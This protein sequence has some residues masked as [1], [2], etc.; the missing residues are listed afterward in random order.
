MK[1]GLKFKG[2][3]ITLC[4]YLILSEC[5]EQGTKVFFK[6]TFQ[7]YLQQ[8]NGRKVIILPKCHIFPTILAF[9]SLTEIDSMR[10]KF[11][12]ANSIV[13]KAI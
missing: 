7:Y 1:V 6:L 10:I 3:K 12:I 5:N 4:N 2:H 13:C 8:I 9:L 11:E